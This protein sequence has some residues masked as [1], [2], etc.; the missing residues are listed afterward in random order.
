MAGRRGHKTVLYAAVQLAAATVLLM[1]FTE[2]RLQ[3]IYLGGGMN[4]LRYPRARMQ[5]LYSSSLSE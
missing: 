3:G 4:P 1:R 2:S 5:S